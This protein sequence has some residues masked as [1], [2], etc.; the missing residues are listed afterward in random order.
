MRLAIVGSRFF[1]DYEYMK[2]VFEDFVADNGAITAIVSG[3]AKGAD[4]LAQ[5]IAN[6][7]N[8]TMQVWPADWNSN[9]NAAGPIRNK[10]I[11]EDSDAMLAFLAPDSR[12]T[13]NSIS[14]ARKKGIDV[15]VHEI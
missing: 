12:G 3:G 1:T 8:I 9:G 4:T 14:L 6:E 5:Q 7:Y 15:E 2:L 10:Q 11:V 13:M